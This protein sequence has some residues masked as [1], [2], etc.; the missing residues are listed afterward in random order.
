MTLQERKYNMDKMRRYMVENVCNLILN[1][2]MVP[3]M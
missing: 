3:V 1:F 2:V